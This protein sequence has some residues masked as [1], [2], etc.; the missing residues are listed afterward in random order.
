MA[1]KKKHRIR[2]WIAILTALILC[3][4]LIQLYAAGHTQPMPKMEKAPET[5]LQPHGVYALDLEYIPQTHQLIGKICISIINTSK[6]NWDLLCFAD[7]PSADVFTQAPSG[8]KTMIENAVIT[9]QSQTQAVSLLR[10]SMNP[11]RWELP[12]DAALLPGEEAQLSFDLT[13]SV[14]ENHSSFGFSNDVC[15]FGNF[16]PQLAFWNGAEWIVHQHSGYSDNSVTECADYQ[17]TLRAPKDFTVI[18]TGESVTKEGITIAHAENVRDFAM[19]IGKG[20]RSIERQY[21]DTLVRCYYKGSSLMGRKALAAACDALGAFGSAI[22]AY[23]YSTLDIVSA[24]LDVAGMEYPQLVMINEDDFALS[25]K[26]FQGYEQ[27]SFRRLIAHEIAHQ[28]FYGV[29]GNDQ[30]AEPWLDEG[31]AYFLEHVYAKYAGIHAPMMYLDI[32]YPLSSSLDVLNSSYLL[33]SNVYWG[34]AAFLDEMREIIGDDAFFAAMQAMYQQFAYQIIDTQ[35]ALNA[36]R[37][38]ADE[39][40]CDDVESLIDR[41]FMVSGQ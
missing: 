5:V 20:W 25:T 4:A 22:G 41:Y 9:R 13:I 21:G 40:E 27:D 18:C 23:P 31:F 35:G 28:W 19:V 17:L 8:G 36:F 12:L 16:I 10:D 15:R 33:Q 29:I 3:I 1:T 6:Q 30:Y 7:W 39:E 37:E 24:D 34:G 11:C 32:K 2:L 26:L 38:A 14:P